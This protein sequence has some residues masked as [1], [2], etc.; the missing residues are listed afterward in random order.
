LTNIDSENAV[1]FAIAIEGSELGGKFGE[2]AEGY[3]ISEISFNISWEVGGGVSIQEV[4]TETS[5]LPFTINYTIQS[6]ESNVSAN[7]KKSINLSPVNPSRYTVSLNSITYPTFYDGNR[8]ESLVGKTLDFSL[9][10]YQPPIRTLDGDEYVEESVKLDLSK[11]AHQISGTPSLV[12]ATSNGNAVSASNLAAM[13]D[14]NYSSNIL[15]LSVSALSY[16]NSS[17][18]TEE[19]VVSDYHLLRQDGTIIKNSK[20]TTTVLDG[21]L[22]LCK[23]TNNPSE[24]GSPT[25]ISDYNIYTIAQADAEINIDYG[26][27]VLRNTSLIENGLIWGFY[28]NLR[29]EFLGS[30]IKYLDYLNRG[31]QNIYIGVLAFDAD[32]NISSSTDVIGPRDTVLT[33]PISIPQKTAYPIYSVKYTNSSKIKVLG[34][35]PT[36]DKFS[37]WPLYISGGSFTKDFYI[38]KKYGWVDWLSKYKSK[39]L[40]A[41]YSTLSQ[42]SAPWSLFL[43]RPYVDVKKER[44][45]LLSKKAIQIRNAPIAFIKEPSYNIEGKFKYFVDVYVKNTADDSWTKIDSSKMMS[46][47]A[48]EGIIEFDN[49]IVPTT[50]SDIYVDYISKSSGIPIKHSAGQRLPLN[51]FLNKESTE[52]DKALYIYI[53]PNRIQYESI[54]AGGSEWIDVPE[55]SS[56]DSV[57]FTYD[58]SIFNDYN[59]VSFDP[60]ALPI[61][62]IHINKSF[63]VK[64]LG[65]EDLRIKGGGIISSE[66]TK[67][68]NYSTVSMVTMM[69]TLPEAINFWDVYPPLKQAYPK[70]GFVVIKLP[71]EVM[72]NFE[73]PQEIYSIIERNI[74]AG[75]A[76]KLQDMEGNDWGVL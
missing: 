64:D 44:P 61:A 18:S 12:S 3:S 22:L 41:Y 17:L 52:Q 66:I 32:G 62:T 4:K 49:D 13:V 19:V 15:T 71:T 63:D 75:V 38:S 69:S 11:V 60:F 76:Y 72:N 7:N 55:Y 26:N 73:N 36:L 37:Q 65:F 25:G 30:S 20:N 33:Q 70:G 10:N 39:N 53:K 23:N 74:T 8:T 59:S 43:G 14:L 58:N 48:K 68:L 51:P 45:I 31:R 16:N 5:T 34:V 54:G 35:N 27:L 42:S 40:R 2:Y 9:T 50:D 28:D 24:L 29:K 21:L 46:V 1:W 57:N 67:D 6:T 47:N 56:S